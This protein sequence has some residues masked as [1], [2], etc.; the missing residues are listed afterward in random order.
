MSESTTPVKA[1]HL[2]TLSDYQSGIARWC[3][4]CGDHGVL[5][6]IQRICTEEQLPPH[7]TVFVSGI[8]C[9]SRFPHYM[10]TY[11]FHGLHGRAMPVACGVKAR[12]PELQVFV[13]SGDGDFFSIGAGHWIHGVRYNMDMT[14]TIFDNGI[15]GLT[16]AQTSPTS[17]LGLKTKTHPHGAI[18]PPM[19]PIQATLGMTN[20]SFLAQ[21]VDWKPQHLKATLQAA[22]KHKGLGIVRV[23][24]RC[25]A[26]TAD[27]HDEWRRNPEKVLLMKHDKGVPVDPKIDKAFK[28]QVEHDPTDINK[29]RELGDRT[30]VLPIGL[31]YVNP[32]AP[33][34][35]QMT[36]AGLEMSNEDKAKGLNAALDKFAVR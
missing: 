23:M 21:T 25:T 30:D 27:L 6:A 18:L 4:G 26:Y 22:Y 11:G 15:Y 3:P 14:L 7:K 36:N 29:A 33:R 19:N 8:G 12:R 10:K 2:F 16:K 31:F 9:S 28:N 5:A 35:D 24:Q 1:P 34:Y 20:L 13:S 32:D 17:P